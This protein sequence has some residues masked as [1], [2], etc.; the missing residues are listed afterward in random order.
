MWPSFPSGNM[1]PMF[2]PLLYASFCDKDRN[3]ANEAQ[4][5]G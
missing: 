3:I 5:S 2:D 1:A 4:S